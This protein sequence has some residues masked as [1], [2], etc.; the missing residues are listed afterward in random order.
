MYAQVVV[1]T[2]QAPDIDSFSYEVP[3]AL[4][5]QIRVGQ[6]VEVPF[7][8]R[9]PMG[10][11]VSTSVHPR[12]ESKS[13][14][15]EHPGGEVL[16]IKPL[17]RILLPTP[18]LLSY[19]IELLKWMAAYYMAPMVNC[20]E[21]MLPPIPKRAIKQT[22]QE[23]ARL[24]TSRTASLKPGFSSQ[25]SLVLV[26]SLNKIPETLAKFPK[27]KNYA[28]YHNELKASGKFEVWQKILNGEVDYIFGSRL[29]IFVPAANLK[30]IIIYDEHDGAYKDERSPYYDTLTIAQKIS[31][32]TK[33]QLKIVDPT[34]RITTYHSLK[35]HIKIQKFSQKTEIVDMQKERLS[36]NYS[37]ISYELQSQINDFAKENK[38]ILLFLNKKK[39]AG[40]LF[41][42]NCKT[43]QY[44]QNQPNTCPNCQSADIFW[45]VLNVTTIATQVKKLFP[46]AK[47]GIIANLR[48]SSHPTSQVDTKIEVGTAFSLYAPLAKK[49][50][51]IAHIQTDSLINIADFSSGEQLYAQIT[52]LKKLLKDSGKLIL[53][54][55]SPENETLNLAS[56][57]DYGSFYIVELKQRKL[58]SYPPF[59]LLV[60]LTLKGKNAEKIF[61]EA[62]NLADRLSTIHYPLF[63]ILG[64]YQSIFWQKTPRSHIIFK[65]R[66]ANYALESRQRASADIKKLI[67]KLPKGWQTEVEP[68]SIQ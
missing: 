57:N 32:L 2:Y 36:G 33:A 61:S 16:K 52:S 46:R 50:D 22:S 63:T 30:E 26:P 53:Q 3:K 28:V 68:S 42:K 5:S 54:T 1:L 41:C 58:L 12:G 34:P 43:S 56:K 25:Q 20:L 7:G 66:L 18:L 48:G 60:K 31:E 23:K 62:Q 21:T 64:P 6:L 44:L 45:N 39:E 10:M 9:N 37:P 27:A 17:S 4:E 15:G 47:A 24:L 55:Y 19:Q 38:N 14:A 11:V 8:K 29:A 59:S 65:Y 13:S 49:Y 40:H 51:L 67:G 35:N